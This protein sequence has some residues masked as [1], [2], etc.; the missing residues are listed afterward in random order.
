MSDDIVIVSAARTAI[1]VFGGALAD[2][3]ASE[4]G[5]TVIRA[6]LERTG[7]PP[8]QIDEVILGQVLTAGMGQNPAR[9]ASLGAG[10][11]VTVPAMT[12]NKVCGS[13]LKAVQLAAQ[14]V[15][16]GDAGIVIAGGQENMSLAPHVLPKSR[17]GVKMGD[18]KM[19]DSMV[20]DG[21]WCAF[22]DCHMGLTA[23]NIAVNYDISREV[24]D[25]F[26]AASQQKTEAAQNASVFADE[27]V[28]VEIPQRKGDP[29]VFDIDEFPRAGATAEGLA[30]LRPAFRKEGTVTAGNASGLN[31]GAAAVVVMTAAKA[32]EL[33]LAPMARVVAFSSAGVEPSVMGTGP[34]PATTQ[35]LQRAGWEL[36]DLD[37][38]EANEAFAAQAISVNQSLGWN[39]DKVNVSGGAI[40]LGH[41]IGASG[42][43]VLVS[44][45]YGMKRTEARRGLATLCIGG[46]QGVAMAVERI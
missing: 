24:Q 35:C 8:E 10:L 34:I 25:A 41:P 3:P 29:L 12:I 14:A 30:K 21:L 33:G 44:L 13:G 38:I 42:A 6:L 37:L 46:G 27:I 40:A 20:N 26:A 28:P 43:R 32:D 36:G 16:C 1:G 31:D 22:D 5:A 9:Q 17:R 7:L 4:L 39:L 19:V 23:E 18:W 15:R 45:L 2:I 11:P